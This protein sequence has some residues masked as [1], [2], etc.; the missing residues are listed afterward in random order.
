MKIGLDLDDTLA[1]I[2]EFFKI[3]CAA[4]FAAGHEIHI[5]AYR[6][7]NRRAETEQE[8]SEQKVPFTELHLPAEEDE[9]A[10]WKA[11]VAGR[12]EL[13]LM[14]DDSPEVLA[15]T[16]RKVKR[17]WLCDPEIF[18]LGACIRALKSPAA[19]AELKKGP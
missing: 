15:H 19:K 2:P 8:L 1:N 3:V 12:L 11:R 13:D 14:I 16:P 17:L 10:P 9:M 5:F 6:D 18:D 4:L 7:E